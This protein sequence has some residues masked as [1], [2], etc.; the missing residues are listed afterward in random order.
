MAKKKAKKPARKF[1]MEEP[2]AGGID[3]ATN[4]G[5]ERVIK[6]TTGQGDDIDISSEIDTNIRIAINDKKQWQNTAKEDIEFCLGRQWTDEEKMTLNEQRRPCMTFNKIKPIIQL[7]AGH[8]I[9][10]HERIQVSPEGGEDALFSE[11]MDKAL[12]HVDKCANLQWKLGY[13][14]AGAERAGRSWIEFY[15]DYDE[16]PIFGK[17]KS[18]YLGPFAVYMDPASREYDLSDAQ[19]GFKILKLSKGKLKQMY[20]DKIDDID[21]LLT[22]DTLAEV[23]GGV[24]G[25]VE[26]DADN[27]GNDKGKSTPG[28]S[29]TMPGD[30][31]SGDLKQFTVVEYWK[32]EYVEKYF[33]YFTDDGSTKEYDTE[34]EAKA[35]V[36]ARSETAKANAARRTMQMG[37][38]P[39]PGEQ[40]TLDHVIRKRRVSRM[41][42]AVKAGEL[43]LTDGLVD[44]PFEPHYHGFPFFQYIAEWYPEAD[45]EEL[46]VQSL[47]RSL[48]D[49]QRE[50]NKARSQFLHILN[51][52]ANSGWI[53][54]DD[55]LSE[56][57][58][59]ELQQ[60]GST[61]GIVIRKK[62]GADLQRIH[63]VEPSL[64]Q[65]TREKAATDDFKEVSGINADLLAV[66][67]SNAP[68][69]KA[70]SLRIQQAITILQPS[71][72]NF[73]FTKRLI[74]EFIFRIVPMMFDEV[75]LEKIVGQ[76]FMAA[77]K[78]TRAS[79]AVFLTQIED[80]KYD[81]SID[82]S[83]KPDTLREETLE[84][85]MSLIQAG[86][87]MPPD[88]IME[89]MSIPNKQELIARVKEY[90]ARQQQ[91]AIAMEAA[92][93]GNNLQATG[94]RPP[95]PAPV[96]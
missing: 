37:K 1:V 43:I 3:L 47:V 71:F 87:P 18:N 10:R 82:E 9:Q 19:F 20:P 93:K 56:N 29:E 68:S 76:Q 88:V 53:G 23:V 57:K 41:K 40:F 67:T 79:L 65:G 96:A 33:C 11:V 95:M 78:L 59:A 46:R 81:V 45:D 62:K 66:D 85:M 50:V 28:L 44:S 16:D 75:K 90:Q 6:K 49:P 70:I 80:G 15:M 22:D 17:L 55:A 36:A 8:L 34:E 4:S 14:F 51:T 42:F 60:F 54:D 58:W 26:G 2:E 13:I 92:K 64:A 94:P 5:I 73:R 48:K 74:G 12:D 61:P 32:R 63:P 69:G 27:Y 21:E 83:G 7:V 38:I 86:M 77:G 30:E 84:N 24:V 39:I 89:F 25:G 31:P 35:E 52:S 72:Q 91:A